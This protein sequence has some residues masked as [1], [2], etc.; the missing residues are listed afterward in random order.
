MLSMR[1]LVAVLFLLFFS[2]RNINIDKELVLIDSLE[3]IIVDAEK[4]LG[5]VDIETLKNT[6]KKVNADLEVLKEYFNDSLEWDLAK[7]L[8]GYN[9]INKSMGKYIKTHSYLKVELEYS[10]TQLANLRNDISKN[11]LSVDSFNVYI[12]VEALAIEE[13]ATTINNKVPMVKNNISR[14]KESKP[15]IKEILLQIA[16]NS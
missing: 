1:Y 14:Y 16:E 10:K 2:C 13:L 12:K 3:Y 6:K 5:D 11:I 7:F 15:R 4:Q 9:L 8:D